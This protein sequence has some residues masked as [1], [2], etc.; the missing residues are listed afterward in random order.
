MI[1][2]LSSGN[3]QG[4]VNY[5]S[6]ETNGVVVRDSWTVLPMPDIVISTLNR[7]AD[8]DKQKIESPEIQSLEGT[9]SSNQVGS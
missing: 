8:E 7:L 5:F 2:L 6:L 4:S 1:P 9:Q 3:V